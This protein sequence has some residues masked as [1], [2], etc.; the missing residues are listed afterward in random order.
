MI[1]LWS[2]EEFEILKVVDP[3]YCSKYKKLKNQLGLMGLKPSNFNIPAWFLESFYTTTKFTTLNKYQGR[4][5]QRSKL[6]IVI[7][8]I[9]LLPRLFKDLVTSMRVA[10]FPQWLPKILPSSCLL[11]S[12][13]AFR[14]H[15]P[16]SKQVIGTPVMNLQFLI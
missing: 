16:G 6:E 7:T 10:S 2:T 14:T 8:L 12:I 15:R 3:V 4:T 13:S 5:W 1:K 9:G 11:L